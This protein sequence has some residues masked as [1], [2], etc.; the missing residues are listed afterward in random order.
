MFNYPMSLREAYTHHCNRAF[1]QGFTPMARKAFN[2]MAINL[3]WD[4]NMETL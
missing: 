2:A 3:G 4:S 1:K